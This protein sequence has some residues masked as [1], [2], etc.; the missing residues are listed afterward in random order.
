MSLWC[1]QH[2]RPLR[3]CTE[4]GPTG[5]LDEP[6]LKAKK[7]SDFGGG[8]WTW[9]KDKKKWVE[10]EKLVKTPF[11]ERT[12]TYAE[13]IGYAMLWTVGAFL[14]VIAFWGSTWGSS[15]RN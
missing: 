12:V 10:A 3:E 4:H 6:E 13:V 2:S 15:I 14:V 5:P 8:Y 7:P 1:D 11:L 9:D